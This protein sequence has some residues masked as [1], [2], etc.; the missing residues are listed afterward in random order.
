MK[1][2]IHSTNWVPCKQHPRHNNHSSLG[3]WVH[4]DYRAKTDQRRTLYTPKS[5][6][7]SRRCTWCM[8]R[9]TWHTICPVARRQTRTFGTMRRRNNPIQTS[10]STEL[11][12]LR[13]RRQEWT[14]IKL[15]ISVTR[16]NTA[17]QSICM[18]ARERES[19]ANTE[20]MK[21]LASSDYKRHCTWVAVP[22]G[23]EVTQSAPLR[24]NADLHPLHTFV[25]EHVV[26]AAAHAAHV[27]SVVCANVPL[28]HV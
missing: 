24:K 25:A 10:A 28:G 27:R 14:H 20:E 12:Q 22:L 3:N 8:N 23:H 17:T 4:T 26:Q 11:V 5:S 6:R 18:R 7:R 19:M 16:Q 1:Q 2:G 21:R 13:T 9:D 15:A